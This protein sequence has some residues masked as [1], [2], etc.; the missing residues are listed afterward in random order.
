MT[1]SAWAHT[2]EDVNRARWLLA[3]KCNETRFP[4]TTHY[5]NMLKRAAICPLRGWMAAAYYFPH[6]ELIQTQLDEYR[7][8][9]LCSW[10]GPVSSIKVLANFMEEK[11]VWR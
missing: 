2:N 1:I 8:L 11:G 4:D 7:D 9:Q 5:Q 10:T 6:C 3:Y